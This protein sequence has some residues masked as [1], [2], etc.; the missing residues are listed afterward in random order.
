MSKV[1]ITRSKLDGLATTIATKS[2]AA[3]PLTIAQMDAAVGGIVVGSGTDTSQ[4]TVD[5]AH[6]LDGYTAHDSTGAA[7]TGTYVPPTFTTQSKT[8][9]PTTSA[10]TIQP[11]SGYD[12]LSSVTVD[13]IPSQYVVPSGTKSITANAT[14]IDVAQYATVD[15][16]VPSVGSWELI[17]S[18]TLTGVSTTST[19]A[20]SAGTIALGS[21]AYTKDDIIWVHV[22]DTAGKR[23]GY[24]YGSDAIFVNANK[25]NGSTS[26]FTAPGVTTIR[27][28]TSSQFASYTGAYGVWGYSITSGGSL[29]VR[30][31]YN[32]S[33]SLTVN[34]D[35]KVDVYKLTPP[36]G[37]TLFA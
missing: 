31:R 1:L 7:I 35:Y 5:A 18:Q 11:D 16:A 13:A 17:T 23:A 22:R 2:G 21:A 8:A 34:G 28:S 6:L 27:Y 15:V 24:F 26:T 4:D 36:S 19:S 32:S 30:K 10:Q 37:M 14:G 3:L 12:G 9:T 29:T 25:A 33:Y 20:A